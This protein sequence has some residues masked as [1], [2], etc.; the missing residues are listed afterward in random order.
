MG[1][2][3]NFNIN[4]E[5]FYLESNGDIMMRSSQSNRISDL[6]NASG[7]IDSMSILNQSTLIAP[8]K[9]LDEV[10]EVIK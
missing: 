2:S 6:L 5:S 7:N 8:R 9:R 1:K 10:G 4:R 3:D